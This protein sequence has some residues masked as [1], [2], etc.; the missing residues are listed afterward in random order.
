MLVCYNNLPFNL[1]GTSNL[2]QFFDGPIFHHKEFTWSRDTS[3]WRQEA[4]ENLLHNIIQKLHETSTW[5]N[6]RTTQ[7]F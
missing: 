1:E 5:T 7:P 3:A 6:K 4:Y 2:V